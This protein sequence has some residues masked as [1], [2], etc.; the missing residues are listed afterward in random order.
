[1]V[2]QKKNIFYTGSAGMFD[3]P[4]SYIPFSSAA[5]VLCVLR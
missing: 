3:L 1:L 5:I 4:C 2:M